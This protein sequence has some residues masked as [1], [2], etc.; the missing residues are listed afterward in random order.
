MG[1]LGDSG[2]GELEFGEMDGLWPEPYM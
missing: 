1:Q 2:F